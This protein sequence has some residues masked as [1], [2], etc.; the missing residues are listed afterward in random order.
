MYKRTFLSAPLLFLFL[1]LLLMRGYALLKSIQLPLRIK[2]K[3]FVFCLRYVV[4]F[5]VYKGKKREKTNKHKYI[6]Q[7]MTTTREREKKKKKKEGDKQK[8]KWEVSRNH[9]RGEKLYNKRKKKAWSVVGVKVTHCDRY[10]ECENV[11]I[12]S[13]VLHLLFLFSFSIFVLGFR[14]LKVVVH[15]KSNKK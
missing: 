12:D 13:R 11:L 7:W 10:S 15:C 3:L 14:K 2:K 6:I 5:T 1:L 4:V 8:A 9:Q